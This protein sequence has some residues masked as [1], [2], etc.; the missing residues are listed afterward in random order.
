MDAV[1]QET[2]RRVHQGAGQQAGQPGYGCL[3]R[4]RQTA[5][6]DLLRGQA[7]QLADLSLGQELARANS[8]L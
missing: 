5:C 8:G 3:E 6:Q 1:R 2:A 7:G 4:P